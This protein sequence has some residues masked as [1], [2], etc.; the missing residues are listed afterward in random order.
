MFSQPVLCSYDYIK[1]HQVTQNFKKMFAA[2]T[3]LYLNI[4]N[5]EGTY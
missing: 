3:Y 4:K 2:V 1:N 5:I